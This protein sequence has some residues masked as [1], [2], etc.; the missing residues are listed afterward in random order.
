[1]TVEQAEADQETAAAK[2]KADALAA[3]KQAVI[4]AQAKVAE[5]SE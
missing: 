4:D 2:A 5:L 1:M 3:A